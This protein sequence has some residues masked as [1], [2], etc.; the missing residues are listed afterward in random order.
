MREFALAMGAWS[1]LAV[2]Q[3]ASA[4]PVLS[5]CEKQPG[6]MGGPFVPDTRTAEAV[7]RAVANGI[8]PGALERYP[9]VT[10]ADAGDQWAVSQ[11]GQSSP[12]GPKE[13]EVSIDAGGGQLSM[14]IDKCTAA[15]SAAVLN[16]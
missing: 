6:F 15:I 3:T 4:A 2:A 5:K 11:T 16:R 12:R 1:S 9:R 13:G 8:V 14:K 7:Y 10:V